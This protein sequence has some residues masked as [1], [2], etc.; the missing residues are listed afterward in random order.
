ML[1]AA[2]YGEGGL[3][4][5]GSR[6]SA[7]RPYAEGTFG[8]ARLSP[9][10]R[11]A[12]GLIGALTAAELSF[13]HTTEPMFGAGGGV[14]FQAGAL[15]VDLGYRYKRILTDDALSSAFS[16]GHEGFDGNQVRVGVG[17]AF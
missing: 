15:S 2:T 9:T 3:R 7:V 17:V 14:M 16:L 12:D 4:F 1:V 5:A 13:L 6:H 11:G 10:V 8:V